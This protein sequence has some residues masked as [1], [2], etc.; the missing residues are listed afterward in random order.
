MAGDEIKIACSSLAFSRK[1][2]FD[3]LMEI[4]SLG[5]K[6]VDIAGFPRWAH[7][8]PAE[9]LSEP[10]AHALQ[11]KRRLDEL[12][13][14]PVAMNAN[15]SAPF[16]SPDPSERRANLAEVQA[17]IEFARSLGVPLLTLQPGVRHDADS[18]R[19]SAQL[20]HQATEQ[21]GTSP[22]ISF[23]P[24]SG[25]V[26]ESYDAIAYLLQHI[27]SLKVTYDPS[28]FIKIGLDLEDSLFM[29][30][31]AGH[32]HL[33]DAVRGDFQAPF[34]K[35]LIDFDWLIARFLE[36]RYSGAISIEYIDRDPE[37]SILPDIQKL[38]HY[39]ESTLSP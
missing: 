16:N 1:P 7:I 5:F 39:L 32:I 2:L 37:L 35:G 38:K 36:H 24:H 30:E 12:S 11:L 34:G 27:P 3:S 15:T 4:S 22:E 19:L 14:E 9:L 29:L 6:F 25:S 26:A 18:L 20:F 13:L 8:Q 17:L 33:R 10:R 28:H 21:A 31:R 23:E